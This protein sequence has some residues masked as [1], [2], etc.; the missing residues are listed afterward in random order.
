[1][2]LERNF[3]HAVEKG[4]LSTEREQCTASIDVRGDE[5]EK[6]FGFRYMSFKEQ[7]RSV[8]R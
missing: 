6:V 4:W 8:V 2:I 3:K 1:M 7:V 5:T